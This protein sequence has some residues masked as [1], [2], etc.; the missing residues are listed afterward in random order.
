MKKHNLSVFNLLYTILSA[1]VSKLLI[2]FDIRYIKFPWFFVGRKSIKLGKN[3]TA[4]YFLRL[5]AIYEDK[6]K[7]KIEIGDNVIFNNFIHIGALK[8]IKISH[9][10]LIGSNVVIIDHNHGDYGSNTHS[11]SPLS[12]PNKRPLVGKEI[13]IGNNVWIGSNVVILPGSKINDGCIVGAN[14]VVCGDFKNNSIIVGNPALV[15]KKYNNNK[16]YWIKNL[17]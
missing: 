13:F 3:F 12:I 4:G 6:T 10:V 17:G 9:N 16:K 11:S 2:S 5:E 15:V 1:L 7:D 14:S 8:K